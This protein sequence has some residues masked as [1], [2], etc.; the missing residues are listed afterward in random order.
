MIALLYLRK[1]ERIIAAEIVDLSPLDI[2]F[3]CSYHSGGYGRAGLLAFCTGVLL[4]KHIVGCVRARNNIK[5]RSVAVYHYILHNFAAIEQVFFIY[6][7]TRRNG[8]LEA[9][10]LQGKEL[11]RSREK[12][13]CSNYGRLEFQKLYLV[14]CF[15]DNLSCSSFEI[16]SQ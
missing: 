15:E 1:L 9:G 5:R 8:F 13:R 3:G 10:K 12:C 11:M 16:M 7:C 4:V 6:M 2:S 14:L